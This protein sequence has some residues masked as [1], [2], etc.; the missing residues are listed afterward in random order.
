MSKETYTKQKNKDAFQKRRSAM[1]GIILGLSFFLLS[2][3]VTAIIPNPWFR[4][5]IQIKLLD[6]FFLVVSSLLIGAYKAVHLYKKK[7]TTSYNVTA[8]AGGMG[9][10]FAFACPICNQLL[11]VL[12]GATALLTYFEPYGPV[13]GFA[14]NGLLAGA[15]YWR[16]KT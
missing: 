16:V 14:S 3:I 13:L 9:S 15:L 4:R 1:W 6:L 8:T 11:V 5:M 2:G 7:K 12:F 10:F